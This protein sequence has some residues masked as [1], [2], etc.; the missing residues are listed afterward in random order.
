M[1]LSVERK[2][3]FMSI[4]DYETKTYWTVERLYSDKVLYDAVATFDGGMP[5]A[6]TY[7]ADSFS[8]KEYGGCKKVTIV[9]YEDWH[10]ET[11]GMP[12]EVSMSRTDGSPSSRSKYLFLNFEDAK[13]CYDN[14]CDRFGNIDGLV[15][16]VND[17]FEKE[18]HK[19]GEVVAKSKFTITATFTPTSSVSKWKRSWGA[20]SL[21]DAMYLVR[22]VEAHSRDKKAMDVAVLCGGIKIYSTS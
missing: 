8:E 7:A 19:T 6:M 11:Y 18:L 10:V 3:N 21:E 13:K 15:I 4:V 2:G 1:F 9:L 14:L 5:D 17:A 12:Y 20:D 16:E 22:M